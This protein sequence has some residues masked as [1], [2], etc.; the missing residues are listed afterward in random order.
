MFIIHIPSSQFLASRSSQRSQR[1]SLT[2]IAVINASLYVSP[3]YHGFA[4]DPSD[5]KS[6]P[7]SFLVDI[8]KDAAG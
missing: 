1:V 2:V 5:G 6:S 8:L 4:L 3:S 7:R